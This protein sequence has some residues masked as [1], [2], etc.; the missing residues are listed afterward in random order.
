[1]RKLVHGFFGNHS[2]FTASKGC[3]RGVYGGENFRP[4]SLTLFPEQKSLMHGVFRP[5]QATAGNGILDKS[6][7][8]GGELYFHALNVGLLQLCVN[9][10]WYGVLV[11]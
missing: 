7:L 11:N 6:F 4:P 9:D 1:M 3:L 5:A 10:G 2:S 8:A